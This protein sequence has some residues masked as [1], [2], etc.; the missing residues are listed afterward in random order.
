MIAA[1]QQ[2]AR[3]W[4]RTAGDRFD[5]VASELVVA[6]AGAGDVDAARAG[7]AALEAVALLDATED[8]AELPQRL[9]DVGAVPHNAAEDA[10]HIA[11]AVTNGVDYL[12]TWNFRHIANAG[13]RSRI[14][15]VCRRAG[16]EPATICTPNELVEPDHADASD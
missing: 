16:Y 2:V 6:E 5:L 3:E 11:I 14:E 10:A 15:R 12:V 8:A 13:M 1:Y 4:W 7:L 9:L